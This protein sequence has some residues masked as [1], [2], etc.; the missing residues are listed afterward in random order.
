[1]QT[2][3]CPIPNNINP[4]QSNGF[5]FGINKLPSLKYFCQEASIPSLTLPPVTQA[6]PFVE[7]PVAGD[8]LQFDELSIVFLIDEDMSNYQA[9]Y[10]WLLGL[11]FPKTRQQYVD[12]TRSQM[13]NNRNNLADYSD[14]VLQILNNSNNAIKTVAFSDMIPTSL[15]SLTLSSTV[16]NTTYLAGQA[17][18]AY[19]YYEFV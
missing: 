7:V 3:T 16:D 18:F 9:I 4:L 8:K 15:G 11:G 1:M 6:S 19:T 12:F 13:F 17:T 5:M 10:E 14:G 2:L